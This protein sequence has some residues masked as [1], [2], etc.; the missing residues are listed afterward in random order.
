MSASSGL[1]A[2]LACLLAE[3]VL[4]LGDL[5]QWVGPSGPRRERGDPT[6]VEAGS[7]TRCSGAVKRVV[8]LC[9][10][11]LQNT[12]LVL[13]LFQELV[14]RILVTPHLT[15]SDNI[16]ARK[17]HISFNYCQSWTL[18][19]WTAV[20]NWSRSKEANEW[21]FLGHAFLDVQDAVSNKKT[22]ESPMAKP[23]PSKDWQKSF[24]E[25]WWWWWWWW[26]WWDVAHI[27]DC[28]RRQWRVLVRNPIDTDSA[29]WLDVVE[30]M[31][32]MINV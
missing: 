20:V 10:N 16:H 14:L 9:A 2:S 28:N 15:R 26:W 21:C 5:Q 27:H 12:D 18:G 25:G 32:R 24:W 22:Q 23:R 11:L 29:L 3:L 6:K 7:A 13:N 1:S 17:K 8:W 4:L 30:M 19:V 31:T